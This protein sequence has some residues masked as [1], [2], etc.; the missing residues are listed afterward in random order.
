MSDV[1]SRLVGSVDAAKAERLRSAEVDFFAFARTYLPHYFSSEPAEYHR[2][3]VDIINAEAFTEEHIG[4]LKPLIKGDYHRYMRP[5]QHLAG[6][7]DVE[8]RGFSKSTR[9]ALAYPLWRVLFKK[10]VFPVIFGASQEAANG[11]ILYLQEEIEQN[12]RLFEDF[13]DL[14]G[15]TWKANFITLSNGS[16]IAARGAGATTRGMKHGPHRPD[17]V[18]CDDILKDDAA[19][20]RTQ[21]DKVYRWF[22]RTVYPLGD[23]SSTLFVVINTIFHNDDIVNRLLDEIDTGDLEHWVGLRFAAFTP[24]G[25]SLWPVAKPPE[26]LE[27]LRRSMGTI[28]FST[29][30]MNE[31]MSD[32]DS[33]FRKDWLRIERTFDSDPAKMRI[34]MG[35]DPATG[36]HDMSAIVV[37][38]IDADGVVRVLDAFGKTM[39]PDAFTRKL[40]DMHQIWKP[41]L[42]GWEDVTFQKVF[43]QTVMREAAR[44]GTHL[45]IKGLLTGGLSKEARLTKL[46]PLVESGLIRFRGEHREL[47][48][49]LITFP[50]GR[51]DDLPDAL[52]YAWEVTQAGPARPMAFA[53]GARRFA[54]RLRG[55]ANEHD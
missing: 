32:E 1:L 25:A 34:Y 40:I 23:G 9:F 10:S 27:R 53:L 17:L 37:V 35:V 14:R 43:R 51:F 46:S 8:P 41:R 29:E 45:P 36:A 33:L 15:D 48:D 44:S 20:S 19:E 12:E 54:R 7:V 2:I 55:Y 24:S 6:I 52:Y 49:Q 26:M 28:A 13:G 5:T 31:P 38:G 22:K 47:T 21:R 4:R 39:S 42:I 16:A 30:M 18:I 3:L 50:K 11:A